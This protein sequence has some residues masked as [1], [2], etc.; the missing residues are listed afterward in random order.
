MEEAKKIIEIHYNIIE[1]F[2]DDNYRDVL[3]KELA[4]NHC[5]L[6]IGELRD[7]SENLLMYKHQTCDFTLKKYKHYTQLKEKIKQL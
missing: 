4:I 2:V 7:L 3:A 6:M 1:K 5:D